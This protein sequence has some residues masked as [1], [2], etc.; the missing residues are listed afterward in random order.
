MHYYWDCFKFSNSMSKITK[1]YYFPIEA[2]RV[3]KS[4][5]GLINTIF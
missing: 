5:K 1:K 4:N 3:I 2:E